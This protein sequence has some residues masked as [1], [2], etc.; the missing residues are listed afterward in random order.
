M[1]DRKIISQ[2]IG[3]ITL[4][5][6]VGRNDIYSIYNL[7]I[8][9]SLN[10]PIE[11]I[12]KEG[13]I[14]LNLEE[15]LE[16]KDNIY[17]R[18]SVLET[19][20]Y[21]E[22]Y[23]ILG[24]EKEYI[25]KDDIELLP[26]GDIVYN[27]NR[28]Y[29]EI[30]NEEGIEFIGNYEGY[31]NSDIVKIKRE[32]IEEIKEKIL[33]LKEGIKTIDSILKEYNKYNN[34][35]YNSYIRKKEKYE[36]INEE[37]LSYKI[38]NP[39][40]NTIVEN[41]ITNRLRE[42]EKELIIASRI[43]E[44]ENK[45]KEDEHYEELYQIN[46]DKKEMYEN[47]LKKLEYEYLELKKVYPMYFLK[48]DKLML[49][50]NEDY[51]L[52]I[53][54]D[55]ENEVIIKYE[56]ERIKEIKDNKDIDIIINYEENKIK[57]VINSKKEEVNIEY[58][59][60]SIVFNNKEIVELLNNNIVSV[61]KKEEY[62]GITNLINGKIIQTKV[63]D[64][65][66][67]ELKYK[68]DSNKCEITNGKN[69][70]KEI[71]TFDENGYQIKEEKI[72][73][74]VIIYLKIEEENE[75]CRHIIEG[76]EIDKIIENTYITKKIVDITKI[77]SPN[78][79][80]YIIGVS[81][82]ADSVLDINKT[83]I[84]PYCNYEDNNNPEFSMMVK[85][86]YSD[87]T[88]IYK[89]YFNPKIKGTQTNYILVSLKEEK[90]E[91]IKVELIVDYSNN[92]ERC[93]LERIRFLNGNYR[94]IK[95]DK[96]YNKIYEY[97]IENEKPYSINKKKRIKEEIRYSY[98]KNGSIRNVS[99]RELE[100][101]GDNIYSN[102]MEIDYEYNSENKLI[103]KKDNKG[104]VVLYK[105]HEKGIEV[106]K[107]NE[108]NINDIYKEEYSTEIKEKEEIEEITSLTGNIKYES[109]IE[110][111]RVLHSD[112][113]GVNNYVCEQIEDNKRVLK[114][115]GRIYKYIY[116]E[117]KR[118]K[119]IYINE[120]LYYTYRYEKNNVDIICNKS[121]KGYRVIKDRYNNVV[122]IEKIE[123]GKYRDYIEYELDKNDNI[124]LEKT[125]NDD[126]EYKY[127]DDILIGVKTKDYEKTI[128]ED[129]NN[130]TIISYN[131]NNEEIIIKSIYEEGLL[132]I[133]EYKNKDINYK[134]EYKYDSLN[135]LVEKI[136]NLFKEKIEYAHKNDVTTYLIVRDKKYFKDKQYDIYYKYDEEGKI[137]EIKEE[138]RN[139]KYTY[140]KLN[141]LKT[142]YYDNKLV[143]YRY[144]SIGNIE[145]KEIII[146]DSIGNV[147]S[148]DVIKYEYSYDNNL[149]L[150]YNEEEIEYDSLNRPVEYRNNKL[151][152]EEEKLI[153]YNEVGYRYNSNGI[154]I[155]KEDRE[156]KVEYIVDG[157]R[158]IKERRIEYKTYIGNILSEGYVSSKE[159]NIEYIYQEEGIVG[160]IYNKKEYYYNKN[161]LKDI[162]EIYDKNNNIVA[163]Y[164]YDAYGKCD[165]LINVD[166]IGN[167]NPYRL[168]V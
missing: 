164:V 36:Q 145:E 121:N 73:K 137:V 143:N 114:T 53:I 115:K 166:D 93:L 116:D 89:D 34:Q 103:R 45:L 162:M 75:K 129:I 111:K 130:N 125:A 165:I 151:E 157:S 15:S 132:R 110:N 95:Y 77:L 44:N 124:V 152:W 65:I 155:G 82:S 109:I 94:H 62:I 50:Y 134:E 26:N 83:K 149:L 66:I 42:A 148:K 55:E 21:E 10:I 87:E 79:K 2:T 120:E 144:D 122:K 158:I 112:I 76:K 86:Y 30:K 14:Y 20:T 80:E 67:E 9:N 5:Y 91:V 99:K 8:G 19:S 139:I 52:C 123:E 102:N 90:S 168:G 113:E 18:K 22:L 96:A 142:E 58:I 131:I 74:D 27:S 4:N 159:D 72:K 1:K 48:K 85:V 104:N 117:F 17:K 141:R 56:S 146:Y 12:I 23:Y 51:R 81:V 33:N 64:I 46:K 153:K 133:S 105:Y 7:N 11:L 160:F 39:L 24:K 35:N 38:Q 59:E 147:V 156:S 54:F 6:D 163:K 106:L 136:N 43:Y 78:K 107:Y 140:D 40:D 68:Y 138:N 25:E 108:E 29:K 98:N 28:V 97:Y 41:E 60:N 118:V 167:I 150:K 16:L 31:K 119:E 63:K 71:L 100:I 128:D 161:I 126:I 57:S 69:D 127:N 84:T 32:E 101:D 37:Y 154:R 49:G 3:D 88:I 47:T 135:R 70:I 61:R 13:M 92:K